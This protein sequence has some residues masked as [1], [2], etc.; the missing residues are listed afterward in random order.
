MKG[1]VKGVFFYVLD[2]QRHDPER[3][4]INKI[5]T[6]DFKFERNLIYNIPITIKR[7]KCNV[8]MRSNVLQ[9]Y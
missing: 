9:I 1:C 4:K 5:R 8:K 2:R 6:D 3:K 7:Y